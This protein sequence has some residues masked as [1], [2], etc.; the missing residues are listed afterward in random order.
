[1]ENAGLF[2]EV[3][4]TTSELETTNQELLD[5]TRVKSELISAMSHELRTPL[6]VIIGN[7]DLAQDEF[8]GP[9]NF[10]QKTAIQKILRNSRFFLKMI[11]MF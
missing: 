3:K 4:K 7:A 6:H 11:M 2:A 10:D 8:F 9:L 5:A 1:M